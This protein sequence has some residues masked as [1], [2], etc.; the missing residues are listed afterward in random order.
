MANESRVPLLERDQVPPELSQRGAVPNMFKTVANVPG[1][2]LGFAALLKPL[3]SDGAL[4]GWYKE[5]IATRMSVLCGSEYATSGHAIS[6]KQKGA[7]DAQIAAVK[8]DFESGP[9]SDHEKLG[10]RCADRLHRSGREL[11]DEFYAKLKNV[12]TD[13]QLVELVATASVFEFFP[14]FV[15][16]LRIP[17]TPAPAPAGKV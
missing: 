6:A 2:A 11:D 1:L 15:D 9:F 4:P 16:G 17:L 3:L 5:L 8:S 10:F 14:R 7:S 13:Q 12:F